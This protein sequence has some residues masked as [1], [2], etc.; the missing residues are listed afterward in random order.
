[1]SDTLS[2]Y[3]YAL[4]GASDAAALEAAVAA[5][6]PDR[7]HFQIPNGF[8]V[9]EQSG[10]ASVVFEKLKGGAGSD[11]SVIV[12]RMDDFYGWHDRAIWDWIEG[13]KRGI[14]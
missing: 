13:A 3:V 8:L 9:A 14:Q 7:L 10:Q 12:V 2:T 4:F 11:F 1:M 6:W 5:K